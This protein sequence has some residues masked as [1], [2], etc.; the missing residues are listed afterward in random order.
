MTDEDP[1]LKLQRLGQEY[2]H[3]DD[4][5][6]EVED[7]TKLPFMGIEDIIVNLNFVLTKQM[8]CDWANIDRWNHEV[9][10]WKAALKKAELKEKD[11]GK[12]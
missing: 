11:D 3:V 4:P 9:S 8:Y 12:Q 1:M 6:D 5:C 2:D 7:V 10:Y